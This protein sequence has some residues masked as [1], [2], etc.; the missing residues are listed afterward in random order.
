MIIQDINSNWVLL[1]RIL[2]DGLYCLP[3]LSSFSTAPF[4]QP[5]TFYSS[6]SPTDYNVW[7]M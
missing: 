6:H 2:N 5:Q 4:V 7:H 1:R 3:S